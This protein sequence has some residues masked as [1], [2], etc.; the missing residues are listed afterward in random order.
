[1]LAGQMRGVIEK[2]ANFQ[3][4]WCILSS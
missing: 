1:L 4:R 3:L 2:F